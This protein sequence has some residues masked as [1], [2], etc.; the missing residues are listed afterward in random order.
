MKVAGGA[1]SVT[2]LVRSIGSTASNCSRKASEEASQ[3][4][5]PSSQEALVCQ[6]LYLYTQRE[7]KEA[8]DKDTVA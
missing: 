4:N 2:S 6:A 5:Q 7:S 8:L 3:V 1:K